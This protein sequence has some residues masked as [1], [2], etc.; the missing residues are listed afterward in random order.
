MRDLNDRLLKNQRIIDQLHEEIKKLKDGQ[1][2]GGCD[3]NVIIQRVCSSDS[4]TITQGQLTLSSLHGIKRG[5]GVY[6]CRVAWQLTLC[7]HTWQV[8]LR[9]SVMARMFFSFFHYNARSTQPSNPP[10]WVN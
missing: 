2:G 4:P 8:K 5:G 9:S 1:G 10:G 3:T 7:D 6:L